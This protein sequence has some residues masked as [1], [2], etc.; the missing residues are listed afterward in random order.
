MLFI[1]VFIGILTW[2][3]KVIGLSNGEIIFSFAVTTVIW[4]EL[5]KHWF[6]HIELEYIE[7]DNEDENY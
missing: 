1:L 2:L 4:W 5:F 6:I 7:E 3:C